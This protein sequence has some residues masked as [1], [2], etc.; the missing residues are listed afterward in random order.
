[1]ILELRLDPNG[2]SPLLT[3]FGAALRTLNADDRTFTAIASP[4]LVNTVVKAAESCRKHDIPPGPMVEAFRQFFLRHLNGVRCAESGKEAGQQQTANLVDYFNASFQQIGL[5]VPPIELSTDRPPASDESATVLLF[6][7]NPDDRK[8]MRDYKH[9]RF[10][11]END[12]ALTTPRTDGMAPYLS[13]D[14]RSTDQWKA[15]LLDFLN[16]LWEWEKD[17]D[18]NEPAYFHQACIIYRG[19]LAI[20]PSPESRQAVLSNY[21]KLLRDNVLERESPPDWYLEFTRLIRHGMEIDEYGRPLPGPA[22]PLDFVR[23]QG[24]GIMATLATLEEL[25]PNRAKPHP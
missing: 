21:L 3:A 17:K 18:P 14:Q 2:F 12:K 23:A 13:R 5:E 4:S 9:L 10:G 7:T 16:E 24:D 15:E 11:G 19:L 25:L 1:M 22:Q 20:T 8:L 6:W